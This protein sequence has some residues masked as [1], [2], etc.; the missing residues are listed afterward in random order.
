MKSL[1]AW[2]LAMG[3]A[4]VMVLGCDGGGSRRSSGDAGPSSANTAEA[5]SRWHGELF[6]YA[7]DNLNHLEDFDSD[8]IHPEIFRRLEAADLARPRLVESEDRFA[9]DDVA[10]AG[11]APAG[12]GPPEPVGPDPGSAG[13]LETRP[14]W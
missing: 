1:S 10:P 2:L 5:V 9:G 7:I 8:E 11:H 12:G 3:T 4:L 13:G 14:A 6:T